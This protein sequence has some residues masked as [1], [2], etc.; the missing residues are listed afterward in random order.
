M[1]NEKYGLKTAEEQLRQGI[2]K[3]W[4]SISLSQYEK[5]NPDAAS[6]DSPAELAQKIRQNM[7]LHAR[8]CGR[9]CTHYDDRPDEYAAVCDEVEAGDKESYPSSAVI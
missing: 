3:E 1:I 9:S 2:A 7:I 4:K 8:T 5:Y 6:A